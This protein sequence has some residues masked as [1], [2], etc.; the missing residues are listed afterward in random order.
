MS[1]APLR[2]TF[3]LLLLA[4]SSLQAAAGA[5]KATA[6]LK[7]TSGKSVGTVE[8]LETPAGA[9]FKIKVSGLPP[10]PHAI[11]VHEAGVCEGDFSSA[12]GI[13]NPVGAEHGF[14]HENGPMAGDLP[15][16]FVPAGGALEAD[17]LN[18]FVVLSKDAEETI[19]SDDGASIVVFE[20]ADDYQTDPEGDAGNRI[21]CG[22]IAPAK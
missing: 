10:G 16:L 12:G 13:Y 14:L 19:F 5:A 7:D 2:F 22:V 17:M 6:E 20:K 9:L 15:N 8:I 18:T 11:H 4:A 21:A 1:I 3:G